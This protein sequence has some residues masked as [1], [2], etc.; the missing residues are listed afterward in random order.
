[1]VVIIDKICNWID[2]L[3]SEECTNRIEEKGYFIDQHHGYAVIKEEVEECQE[4]LDKL[5]NKLNWAWKYTRENDSAVDV[6]KD[7]RKIAILVASEATQVAAMCEKFE[8]SS[9]QFK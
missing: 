3:V 8:V 6:V 4:E 9:K 2:R 7:M 1:M 5:I